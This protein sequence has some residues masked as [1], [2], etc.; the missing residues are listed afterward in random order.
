MIDEDE[1]DRQRTERVETRQAGGGLGLAWMVRSAAGIASIDAAAV[2]STNPHHGCQ[3]RVCYTRTMRPS[4]FAAL[5]A[6]SLAAASLPAQQTQSLL[7]TPQTIV[8]GN[9]NGRAKPALTV[10]SG[11][12]VTIQT[13]STCG[14]PEVLESRGV[15]AADIPPYVADIFKNFPLARRGRAATS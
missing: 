2:V 6:I 4:L 7:A 10:H 13:L 9:Y 5:S 3:R 14:A 15:K 1:Q 11:D 12:T 8:W